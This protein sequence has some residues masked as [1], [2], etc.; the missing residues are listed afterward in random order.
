MSPPLTPAPREAPQQPLGETAA[1]SADLQRGRAPTPALLRGL[2][3]RELGVLVAVIS[4][5]TGREHLLRQ[6]EWQV[7]LQMDGRR[8]LPE[9][10]RRAR[11][12]GVP[13]TAGALASF[14]RELGARGLL[15]GGSPPP[16]F[17]LRG[18]PEEKQRRVQEALVALKE[19]RYPGARRLLEEALQGDPGCEE[20]QAMLEGVRRAEVD[21]SSE[22]DEQW[23]LAEAVRAA[24]EGLVLPTPLPLPAGT[25]ARPAQ[26]W[27]PKRRAL[28]AGA[29]LA[30]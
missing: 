1:A 28:I 15:A 13:A 5:V 10:Q 16:G 9:L 12:L 26:R 4:P 14:V 7:A 30:L 2:K 17:A 8:T 18:W 29:A 6:A 27:P 11:R 3:P 24:G 21:A 22:Q 25:G 19:E 20:L 23:T